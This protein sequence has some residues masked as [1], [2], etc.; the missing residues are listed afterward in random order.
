MT[1]EEKKMYFESYLLLNDSIMMDFEIN[2]HILDCKN[3]VMMSVNTTSKTTMVQSKPSVSMLK[4][5]M[6]QEKINKKV[7]T[8]VDLRIRFEELFNS[9]EDR[10]LSLL[11]KYKYIDGLEWED[12]AEKLF[13]SNEKSYLY[14]LLTK[15]VD[16]IDI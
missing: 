7:N 3:D 5:L 6:V 15:A 10:R 9:L 16:L 2:Q 8:M 12:I 13:I 4:S 14:R 1:T 11:L